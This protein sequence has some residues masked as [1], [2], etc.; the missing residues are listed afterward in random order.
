MEPV[1]GS[2]IRLGQAVVGAVVG[3]LAERAVDRVLDGPRRT[4]QPPLPV[5][6]H[7]LAAAD[8][9]SDLDVFV[10]PVAGRS[11]RQPVILAFQSAPHRGDGAPRGL[12]LPMV[13]GETAHLRLPRGDYLISALI[14]DLPAAFGGAPVLRGIGQVRHWLAG[15][16]LDRLRITTSA[17]TGALAEQLGLGRS[18]SLALPGRPTRSP[19]APATTA[20]GMVIPDTALERPEHRYP[21]DLDAEATTESGLVIP[22]TAKEKPR[23]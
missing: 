12:A 15:N 7:W 11:A 8:A 9:T 1:T 14:V 6:R 5:H 17:P 3:R 18:D 21:D 20:S 19:A 22:D 4:I 13:L 2:L 23:W 16:H 10:A